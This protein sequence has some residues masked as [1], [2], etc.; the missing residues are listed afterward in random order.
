M[1]VSSIGV[2]ILRMNEKRN[3][4]RHRVLKAGTIGIPGGGAIDCMV[5]N[6]SASGAAVEVETPLGIPDAF[7]LVIE[8]DHFSR[9]CRVTWRKGKRIGVKFV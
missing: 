8:A 6:M 1:Q 5:R 4:Q 2:V 3:A 7:T 9:P